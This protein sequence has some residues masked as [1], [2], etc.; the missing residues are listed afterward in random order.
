MVPVRTSARK[1]AKGLT[2]NKQTKPAKET[3][4]VCDRCLIQA[5]IRL[6]C[7]LE[8]AQGVADPRWLLIEL[9]LLHCG[10]QLYQ[11]ETLCVEAIP[12]QLLVYLPQGVQQLGEV[13]FPVL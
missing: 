5:E 11:G 6:W 3:F 13:W 12:E 1:I 2:K 8:V 9:S 4:L 7:F 10:A